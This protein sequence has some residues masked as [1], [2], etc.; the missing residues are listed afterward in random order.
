MNRVNPFRKLFLVVFL[1]CVLASSV[2]A[3]GVLPS[4]YVVEPKHYDTTFSIEILN[5]EQSNDI[6]TVQAVGDLAPYIELSQQSIALTTEENKLTYTLDLP[7]DLSP[8]Q[9]TADI[10]ISPLPDAQED[11]VEIK[12]KF[13]VRHRVIVNVAY[14]E[15]Y[16]EGRVYVETAQT[17][18]PITTV[19]HLANKGT[20]SSD[21]IGTVKLQQLDGAL[22][23]EEEFVGTLNGLD[24]NKFPVSLPALTQAGSYN[25]VVDLTTDFQDISFSRTFEIGER[26]VQVNTLQLDTFRLGE[27]SRLDLYVENVWNEDFETVYADTIITNTRGYKYQARGTPVSLAARG[28]AVL[29]IFWDTEDVDVGPY[30][31]DITLYFDEYS[32]QYSFDTQVTLDTILIEGQT[33]TGQVTD[34]S[35]SSGRTG[36]VAIFLLFIIVNIVWFVKYKKKK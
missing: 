1:F 36:L 35:T 16:I 23:H 5:S 28:S 2:Q 17:N 33:P 27:I 21:F 4:N 8:G 15:S 30:T 3:I 25:V 22:I 18:S 20:L 19:L 9:H 14:P 24:T 34:V 11:R 10:V 12:A 7:G 31:F 6:Y 26:E 32:Q 29:P 13:E